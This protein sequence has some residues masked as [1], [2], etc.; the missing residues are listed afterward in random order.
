MNVPLRDRSK[1]K[2]GLFG[3]AIVLL[4]LGGVALVMG[5]NDVAIRSLAMLA[6]IISVY[7]VRQ[8]NIFIRPASA[9]TIIQQTRSKLPTRPGR[10]TWIA[11]II[12]LPL[13]GLSFVWL[14][15]DAAHGYHQIWPVYFFTGKAIIC[16]LYLSYL[17]ARLLG[18]S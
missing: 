12:L 3:L 14:Y 18:A 13:L 9:N 5:S 6:I 2:L 11:S 8:S 16:T 7:C 15:S 1:R 10:S 17:V 4:L